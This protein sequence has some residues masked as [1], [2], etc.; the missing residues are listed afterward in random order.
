[1]PHNAKKSIFKFDDFFWH[2]CFSIK[3]NFEQKI[4]EIDIS[5]TLFYSRVLGSNIE[6]LDLAIFDKTN[7]QI[8][9]MWKI[10]HCVIDSKFQG[11]CE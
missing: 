9:I 10:E 4:R 1:M 3:N 5:V 2:F 7:C 11:K 8:T 6:S